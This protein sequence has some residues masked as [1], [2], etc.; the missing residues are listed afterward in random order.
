MTNVNSISARNMTRGIAR[1]TQIA[2]HA[3]MVL[4]RLSG[5]IN[6]GE[7][8]AAPAWIIPTRV[9]ARRSQVYLPAP[10]CSRPTS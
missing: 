4:T 1:M 8:M 3:P 6:V 2:D 5:W 10:V 7:I 9:S